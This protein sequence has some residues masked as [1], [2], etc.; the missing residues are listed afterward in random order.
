MIEA[1]GNSE[2]VFHRA[3]DLA[4]DPVAEIE[5]LV[6]LGCDRVLTSGGAPNAEK[7]IETIAAMV[8]AANGRISI[9]AGSGVNVNNA[10]KILKE[11]GADAVHSTARSREESAMT[12]HRPGVSMGAPGS[13]EYSRQATNREVVRNIINA[14]AD[15]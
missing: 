13:D 6:N 2:F 10:A 1:A 15:I 9:M 5:T 11:T 3:I 12:Y 4:A 7:G 14:V 8:R